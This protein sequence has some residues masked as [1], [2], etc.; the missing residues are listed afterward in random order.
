ML[1]CCLREQSHKLRLSGSLPPLGMNLYVN[2][3]LHLSTTPL[4][5]PICFSSSLNKTTST[6]YIKFSLSSF[7]SDFS[8]SLPPAF[9]PSTL[10]SHL[11]LCVVQWNLHSNCSTAKPHRDA[12][13]AELGSGL[14][15][16]QKVLNLEG[17]FH[18]LWQTRGVGDFW[19]NRRSRRRRGGRN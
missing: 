9:H 3:Y 15:K 18:W 6:H 5:F 13:R 10:P 7:P 12:M 2:L 4:L 1:V 11:L 8:F 19:Y 16:L 14:V 17:D